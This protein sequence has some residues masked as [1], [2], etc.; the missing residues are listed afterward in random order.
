M[1]MF[2]PAMACPPHH[3]SSTSSRQGITVVVVV[4]DVDVDVD[5]IFFCVLLCCSLAQNNEK[6]A[7]EREPRHT[8]TERQRQRQ[9]QRKGVLGRV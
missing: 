5:I 6:P 3:A 8:E 7:L 1:T 9:R 4:V 2:M